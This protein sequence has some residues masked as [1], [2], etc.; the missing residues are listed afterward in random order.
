MEVKHAR[1]FYGFYLSQ[2][3]TQ[4]RNKF[5]SESRRQRRINFVVFQRM[6]NLNVFICQHIIRPFLENCIIT[7]LISQIKQYHGIQIRTVANLKVVKY[8][9]DLNNIGLPLLSWSEFQAQFNHLK[10]PILMSNNMAH[11]K[12]LVPLL[13][14]PNFRVQTFQEINEKYLFCYSPL[15]VCE[16]YVLGI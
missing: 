10:D 4:S 6:Q 14:N 15:S 5:H 8:L 7:L 1:S 12:L 16:L 3:N 11:S 9:A 13:T 2:L